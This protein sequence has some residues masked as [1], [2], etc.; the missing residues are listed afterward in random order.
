MTY[1]VDQ[2]R[3]CGK[4]I[5]VLRA[6]ALQEWEKAQLNPVIP[7]KQWRALGMLGPPTRMQWY[8]NL[9]DGCC[10]PCGMKMMNRRLQ[11][12][13]RGLALIAAFITVA[14]ITSLIILYLPH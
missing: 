7:E 6:T 1:G 13:R 8:N 14:V 10:A 3:M 12:S 4:P 5:A 9:A 2:C 11:Y